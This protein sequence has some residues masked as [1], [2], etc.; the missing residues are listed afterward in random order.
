MPYKISELPNVPVYRRLKE[1]RVN[2]NFNQIT[3]FVTSKIELTNQQ[4]ELYPLITNNNGQ[5]I[6]FQS[7]S[8]ENYD[9]N[10]QKIIVKNIIPDI[11]K[12][13]ILQYIDTEF[14]EL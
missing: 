1:L 9:E 11:D 5:L 12:S 7:G 3:E 4:N 10:W 14:R 13:L 8:G 2:K 6:F